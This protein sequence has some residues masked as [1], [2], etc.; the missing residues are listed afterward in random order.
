MK[1][2]P[3]ESALK[4]G[5][6]EGLDKYRLYNSVSEYLV[7]V[8]DTFAPENTIILIDDLHWL[9]KPSCEL[10]DFILRSATKF[11]KVFGTYRIEEIK[12]SPIADF[13]GIW[14]REKLHTQ[15]SVAPLN[16]TQT[17][18]MLKAI[19]GSVPHAGAKYVY[20]QSG[21]VPFYI[22][23]ILRELERER[24]LY[25]N[26]KDWTFAKK[27]EVSIPRSI[28]ETIKRK[29]KF[30]DA[31]IKQYLELAAVYGQ[32]FS[33]EV[34]AMASKRNV[35]QI[36]DAI[37]ELC[38]LGFLKERGSNNY[39]FSEDIVRQIVYQ[40]ISRNALL[41]YHKAVG[42]T[43]EVIYRNILPNYFEQLAVHF[44]K[45]HDIHKTLY[46]SKCAAQK[47]KENYAHSTAVK[48]FE[49]YLKYEDNPDEIF[50]IKFDLADIFLLVGKYD[51][52]I[53]HLNSCLKINPN[54]YKVYEKLGKAA[55]NMG[56]YKNSLEYYQTGL[57]LTQ[58]TDAIHTF[59]SAIAW[60]HTRLGEYARA[61]E[62]CEKMLKKKSQISRQVLGDS[63]LIL[64]VVFTRLGKFKKAEEYIRKSLKI[65]K[66]TGD[67]RRIAACYL[68]LGLNYHEKYNI[69]MSQKFYNRSLKL[70]EEIGHQQG[71]LITYN[72]IGALYADRDLPKA[73]QYYL[74]ALK[75]AKLIGAKRTIVYLH[76]N[77][78]A[79]E[80]NRMMYDQTLL[81]YKESLSLSKEM[82]F[83]EGIIFSNIGLSDFY[84]EKGK[85]AKGRRYLDRAVKA[86]K[87]INMKYLNIDCLLEEINY[88]LLD[89]QLKKADALSKDMVSRLRLERNVAYKVNSLIYRGKIL[90]ERKQYAKAHDYYK[91]GI[92]YLKSFPSN[93]LSGEIYY[94]RGIAYKKQG[95]KKE[96]LKMFL[97]S[98]RIFS[99]SGNLRFIDKIEK[100]IAE[101]KI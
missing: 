36:L 16:E 100:E 34:I 93:R 44:T 98:S 54:S 39:F 47:A 42:E 29:L 30:L 14:S 2:F 45:A 66:T 80:F 99:T 18:H 13:L 51:K 56:D 55:E 58:G 41:L 70:Y 50:N 1:L 26:G 87:R 52:A 101:T 4:V 19:I 94:L 92:S 86:A 28:S 68:D 95:K 61:Q 71:I 31:E 24:K 91:K 84:R 79:I 88:L 10:L 81:H 27:I 22:E 37:D 67:K 69:K 11:M 6:T 8:S 5:H 12:K 78:G 25:W 60:L 96:A 48:F 49:N 85:L 15:I 35:G 62:E 23:E 53:E 33:T 64:G 72:N 32:E 90:A 65:R 97:E 77:L 21:G 9:D 82:N 3:A 89:R 7:K 20:Q 73:E 63:Y 40:N 38:D 17:G 76:F 46:Y 75:Q 57:D 43:I 83:H 59:K 74:K